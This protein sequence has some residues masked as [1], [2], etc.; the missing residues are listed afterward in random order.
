MSHLTKYKLKSASLNSLANYPH[1]FL[2]GAFHMTQPN[3]HACKTQ[4]QTWPQFNHHSLKATDEF[5]IA[6]T[7]ELDGTNEKMALMMNDVF[8]KKAWRHFPNNRDILGL[9]DN[10]FQPITSFVSLALLWQRDSGRC[11]LLGYGRKHM[12]YCLR[13]LGLTVIFRN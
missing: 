10:N 13:E 9:G 12:T 6:N 1:P 7:H 8:S 5:N 3:P 2:Q 11:I 4:V